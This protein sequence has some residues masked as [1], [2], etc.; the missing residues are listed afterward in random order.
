MRL[1]II[2]VN[3]NTRAD[4]E[5]CLPSLAGTGAEVIVVDNDGSAVGVEALCPGVIVLSQAVNRWFCAGNNIGLAAA[6]R[7]YAL[8]LNPDTIVSP[9][10]LAA[11]VDFMDAH[12][13]YAGATLQLRYPDGTIQRTCSR[14]PGYGYLLLANTPLG[15]LL[16]GLRQRAADRHWYAGWDRTTDRDVAVLPGSCLL[17][18]RADL[19]LNPDLLLYFPE[20]DLARRW[21]GRKFRYLAGAHII[22][23]EKAATRTW[24]AT[25]VYFR[26]LLVYARVW[27]GRAGA[28][29]LWLLTRPLLAAMAVKWR[30]MGNR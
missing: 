11:L 5:R 7:D 15:L 12:P 4:I 26:D 3:Y 29:L 30:L 24:T 23:R 2:I 9:G 14:R 19:R 6:T 16:P 17:M 28:A 25:R 8:L 10:A 21:A 20:D 18:R 1:S 27:H 22:H 13:D